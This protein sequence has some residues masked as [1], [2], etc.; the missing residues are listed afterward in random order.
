MDKV[1]QPF[2]IIH[3]IPQKI[4]IGT[5]GNIFLIGYNST[6]I[7]CFVVC[8]N[9]NGQIEDVLSSSLTNA[10]IASSGNLYTV[11]YEMNNEIT[12]P[13]IMRFCYNIGTEQ[14]KQYPNREIRYACHME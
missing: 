4:Y 10:V 12:T 5:K 7:Q 9:E 13:Y 11:G 3:L 14:V 2:L 8:L 1:I 6:K